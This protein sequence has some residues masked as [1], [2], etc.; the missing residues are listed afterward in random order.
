MAQTDIVQKHD[1]EKETI[2]RWLIL[3][4]HGYTLSSRGTQYMDDHPLFAKAYEAGE[5]EANEDWRVEAVLKEADLAIIENRLLSQA[6]PFKG[7]MKEKPVVAYDKDADNQGM[8]NLFRDHGPKLQKKSG[9]LVAK[10]KKALKAAGLDNTGNKDALM[11]RA[12]AWQAAKDY[13]TL[14]NVPAA[15]DTAERDRQYK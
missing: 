3:G 7:K 15:V 5:Y 13:A 1:L 2:Y 9:L 4:M 12:R 10:L 6:L 11:E 14:P 8:Q